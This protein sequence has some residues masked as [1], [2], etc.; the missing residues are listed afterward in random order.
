MMAS[1]HRLKAVVAVAMALLV[2]ASVCVTARLMPKAMLNTNKRRM[3]EHSYGFFSLVFGDQLYVCEL[4]AVLSCS[5]RPEL[6][7]I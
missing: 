6:P 7:T 3:A 4:F 5:K 2:L 1:G